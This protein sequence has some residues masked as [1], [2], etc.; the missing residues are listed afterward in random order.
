MILIQFQ[1]KPKNKHSMKRAKQFTLLF[2]LTTLFWYSMVAFV[3]WDFTWIDILSDLTTGDRYGFLM[4]IIIKVG[5]DVWA[6]VYIKS[7][8]L[9][10][11]LSEEARAEKAEQEKL[12][13]AFDNPQKYD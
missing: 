7:R 3:K 9:D 13:N 6:W 10:K 1:D 11:D 2:L 4:A 12:K 5:I 8:Y